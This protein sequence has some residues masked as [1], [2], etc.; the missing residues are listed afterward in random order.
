MKIKCVECKNEYDS[1]RVKT[2]YKYD[3]LCGR[4]NKKHGPEN[5]PKNINLFKS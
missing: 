4:C 3:F 1:S 2:L 5:E